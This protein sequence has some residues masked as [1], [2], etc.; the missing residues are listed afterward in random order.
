VGYLLDSNHLGGI[1][2]QLHAATV[3]SGLA[4]GGI[5]VDRESMYVPCPR[6][7]TQVVVN[8]DSFRVGWTATVNTPGP[9]IVAAGA[10]WTVA[11]GSGDLVALDP[12]SGRVVSSVHIGSVPSRFTSAAAGGGRVVVAAQRTV[13]AFGA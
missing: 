13:L 12:S 6:G 9:T 11:T 10:V 7:V 4:Y 2:G 5:A 1:G 8:G 3:C